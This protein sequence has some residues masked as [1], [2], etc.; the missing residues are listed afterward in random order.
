MRC[1]LEMLKLHGSV[2]RKRPELWTDKGILRHD[3]A[4]AY[5]ALRV[6]GFQAKKSI[7]EMDHPPY[8]SDAK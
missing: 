8:S 4:L 7:T 1:Y 5:D 2:Q 3:N 6:Q